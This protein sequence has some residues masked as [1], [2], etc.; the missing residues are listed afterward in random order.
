MCVALGLF[1]EVAFEAFDRSKQIT[2]IVVYHLSFD[3]K[4][5]TDDRAGESK[6]NYNQSDPP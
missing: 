3:L 4:L 6:I 1:S 5:Q 2:A